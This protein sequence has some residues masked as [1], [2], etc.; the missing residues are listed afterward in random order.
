[1]E[2]FIYKKDNVS[3]TKSR[4]MVGSQTYAMSGITSVKSFEKKPQRGG[5]IV[6]AV[7]GVVILFAGHGTA[8][9]LMVGG[10]LTAI[11]ILALVKQKA[12]YSVLLATSS[13][14]TKALESTDG[15][16]I[17]SVVSALNE[18]IVQRG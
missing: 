16:L 6:L 1:M 4:F 14:E 5:L 9:P 3:V 13:G 18:S 12:S 15:Q 2:E 17:T 7:V 8:G 10:I 11:A